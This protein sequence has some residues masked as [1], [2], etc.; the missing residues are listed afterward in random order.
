VW[1]ALPPSWQTDVQTV[2][3]KAAA[4]GDPELLE[5]GAK[6]SRRAVALLASKKD[7]IFALKD[8]PAIAPILA[9]AGEEMDEARL[10]E[11]YDAVVD[12]LDTLVSSEL[13]HP[14]DLKD[15]DV[16]RFLGTTGEEV[17]EDL[18]RLAKLLPNEDNQ[19][20]ELEQ[21]LADLKNPEIEVVASQ[22]ESATLKITLGEETDDLELVRVEGRW[23][24]RELASEWDEGVQQMLAE[25]EDAPK[26]T[27]EQKKQMMNMLDTL[28]TGLETLERAETTEE[29]KQGAMGLFAS[30]GTQFMGISNMLR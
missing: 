19:L 30:I 4:Q 22:P 6:V 26:L 28:D 8:D 10:R 12:L 24:P 13:T 16:G 20:E 27:A 15:L 2:L 14:E 3:R 5:K 11:L 23:V 21:N 1:D 25:L 9:A 7:L 29:L 18:Q 17:M